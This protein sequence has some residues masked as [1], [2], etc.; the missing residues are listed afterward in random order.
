MAH[1]VNGRDSQPKTLG[2]KR[3][4]GQ[5]VKAGTI[6][7]KQRGARFKPGRNVGKATDDTLFALIAG[8]VKFAPNKVVSVIAESK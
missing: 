4:G 5:F 1:V 7:L 8:T 2:V 3:S 6:I